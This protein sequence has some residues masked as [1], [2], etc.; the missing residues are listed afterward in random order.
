M[1][2]WLKLIISIGIPLLVGFAGS[3]FTVTGEGSWYQQINK[4][5]WNPPGSVFGPVWT[6]LYVLMGIAFFLVWKSEVS[7]VVKTKAMVLWSV[8][9]LANFLWS[10]IFFQRH[11]IGLAFAEILVLWVLIL[12]TI[13]AFA[14]ISKLAA[15]LL[16]PYIAWVSFA[17]ILTYTIWKMNIGS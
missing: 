7:K 17:S 1:K 9:L 2:T 16:V 13:F 8:Q 4:P 3:L 5:E 11:E 12:L 10:Y 14:E 6:T 15:W